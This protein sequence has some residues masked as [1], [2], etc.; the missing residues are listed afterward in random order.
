M[1]RATI[2]IVLVLAAFPA[3]E[4]VAAQEAIETVL[5]L[6]APLET[7]PEAK[8]IDKARRS[9]C[10]RVTVSTV[11]RPNARGRRRFSASS[12]A[13][14][15]FH[16]LFNTRLEPEHL[17]TLKVFTPNGHMYR[18]YDVPVESELTKK[19]KPTKKVGGYPYPVKVQVARPVEVDG[20]KLKVVS[21]PFPVAGSTI[22][23]SSLYGKWRVEISLDGAAR[24]CGRPRYFTIRE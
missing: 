15:V 19:S 2:L 3:V 1:K 8:A 24:P 10:A 9:R 22:V 6:E 4:H 14:L 18:Q 12:S 17:V 16:V 20:T 7:L 23:T 5:V 13:D 21:V 11:E